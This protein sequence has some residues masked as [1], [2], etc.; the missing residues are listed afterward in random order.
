M[1]NIYKIILALLT[2]LIISAC[3]VLIVGKANTVVQGSET[4]VGVDS[5]K[6]NIDNETNVA[7]NLKHD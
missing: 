7:K 1:K 2:L 6:I 3:T 4:K 5:T